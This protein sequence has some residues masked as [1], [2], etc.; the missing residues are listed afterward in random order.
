MDGYL[1]GGLLSIIGGL[2]AKRF[3]KMIDSYQ[4]THEKDKKYIDIKGLSNLTRNALVAQGV[5]SVIASLCGYGGYVYI[6]TFVIAVIIIKIK[7]NK[8]LKRKN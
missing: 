2:L 7:E 5:V 4:C 1:L 8:Y 6:P 3:P